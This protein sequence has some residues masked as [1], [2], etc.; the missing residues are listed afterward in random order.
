MN[1]QAAIKLLDLGQVFDPNDVRVAFADAV[2][3]DHPD[4]GG[5]GTKIS[6]LKQARD[7]LLSSAENDTLTTDFPCITCK[8]SGYVKAKMAKRVCEACDGTGER[9]GH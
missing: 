3:E 5:T 8:G 4:H 6:A 9:R 7:V 2:L 1:R